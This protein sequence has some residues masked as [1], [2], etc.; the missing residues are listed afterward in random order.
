VVE[1]VPLLGGVPAPGVPLMMFGV[2]WVDADPKVDGW[3]SV[4][5]LGVR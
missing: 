2:F 3:F 4:F 5:F 1:G